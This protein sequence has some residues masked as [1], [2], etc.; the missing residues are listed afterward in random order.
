MILLLLA[1]CVETGHDCDD[2][3]AERTTWADGTL[4]VDVDGRA[5]RVL[6]ATIDRTEPGIFALRA[7]LSL[8][9]E[10]C[11]QG[12]GLHVQ[13]V[14]GETDAHV[15]LAGEMTPF[16]GRADAARVGDDLDGGLEAVTVPLEWDEGADTCGGVASVDLSVAWMF[17]PAVAE[18]SSIG[19]VCI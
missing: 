6:S 12:T 8:D 5:A 3:A 17:D 2:T 1:A 4:Q 19:V 14:E 16:V 9:L 15:T 7:E 18:R 10:T 11:T 13:W